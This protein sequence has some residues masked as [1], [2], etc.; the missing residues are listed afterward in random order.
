MK[1]LLSSLIIIFLSTQV[2]FSQCDNL[3]FDAVE[4]TVN[5]VDPTASMSEVKSK[6]PCFTGETE[7]GGVFNYGGGI[8][9]LNHD[10]Y[11][12]TYQNFID[13]R[14]GFKGRMSFDFFN[15]SQ[16]KIEKYLGRKMTKLKT[17]RG[18]YTPKTGSGDNS[19]WST[20][21]KGDGNNEI[22]Y[23]NGNNIIIVQFEGGQTSEVFAVSLKKDTE[24]RKEN[25]KNKT[26]KI[27]GMWKCSWVKEEFLF[28]GDLM[29]TT[30]GNK[31]K[32]SILWKIQR[33]SKKD[34]NYYKNKIG[35]TGIE[36][37]EGTYDESN[38]TLIFKGI[39]KK[40]PNLIIG[41]DEYKLSVF[42]NFLTGRTKSENWAGTFN[43]NKISTDI[44]WLNGSWKGVGYQKN[45]SMNWNFS[46]FVDCENNRFESDYTGL[47][48]GG[49]WTLLK[50][51]ENKAY[52]IEKMTKGLDLCNNGNTITVTKIDDNYITVTYFMP[53]TGEMY[54]YSTLEKEK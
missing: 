32:G 14:K 20:P 31:V 8:F 24:I 28:T 1:N 19:D 52:F 6:L 46:L 48:C 42:D 38:G 2:S 3:Y 53:E 29:L 15:N 33:P 22:Y 25:Q 9:F 44:S 21:F 34:A 18:I 10:F 11:F 50:G 30:I 39:S 51:D 41:L 26:G 27:D 49:E 7:E 37:I 16:K 12:Y 43:A 23:R 35:L 13:I 45:F 47:S 40:G 17:I 4:G 36:F 54:V 5:G